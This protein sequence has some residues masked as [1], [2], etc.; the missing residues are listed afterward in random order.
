MR[1]APKTFINEERMQLTEA[2]MN[3]GHLRTDIDK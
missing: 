1:I 3:V 2:K